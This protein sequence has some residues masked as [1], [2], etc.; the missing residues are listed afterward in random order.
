MEALNFLRFW[1]KKTQV[2]A[3]DHHSDEGDNSFIDLELPFLQSNHHVNGHTIA[4][5]ADQ[6][7]GSLSP[8]IPIEA[9]SK[10]R[11]T[12][13]L[14]ALARST[15][16]CITRKNSFGKTEDHSLKRL[17][18]DLIIT[19]YLNVTKYVKVSKNNIQTHKKNVSGGLSTAASPINRKDDLLQQDAI[20]SAILHCKRSL[21]SSTES[22]WLSRCTSDSS[23]A[24]LSNASSTG[25]TSNYSYEKLMDSARISPEAVKK[26]LMG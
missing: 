24:Q 4:V 8:I 6:K 16:T 19:T 17:P 18:K 13:K 10:P 22:S 23:Q 14:G 7:A 2:L 20:Q 9:S 5:K 21:N 25:T 15:S 12:P 11:S 1:M 26:T 3:S